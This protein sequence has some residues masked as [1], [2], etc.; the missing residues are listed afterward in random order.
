MEL[1]TDQTK[2]NGAFEQL[3]DYEI[4]QEQ[5]DCLM[6]RFLM[7]CLFCRK[8]QLAGLRQRYNVSW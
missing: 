7:L 8:E 1:L 6:G 5:Q 3:E 4:D 2:L